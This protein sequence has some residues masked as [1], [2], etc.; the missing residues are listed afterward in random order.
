ML[1]YQPVTPETE[2]A[3]MPGTTHDP[4]H[5]ASYAF[6]PE[7]ENLVVETWLEPGGALPPHQHPRQEERWYA[8]EGKVEVRLGKN[9]R[10]IG[11]EDGEILV[12]PNTVHAV[13][14]VQSTTVHLGCRVTPALGLQGFLE[15]SAAAARDGLFMKGGIPKG[16]KG[17]RWAAAFLERYG[18]DVV[19]TF[20]PKPVRSAMIAMFGG[21]GG[22]APSATMGSDAH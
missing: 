18:D 2:G 8:I 17:A 16:L 13:K 4:V 3:I 5:R 7:G 20:P 12:P 1:S 11:P 14:A 22:S 9:K 6:T 19:M 15:E 10:V 21:K